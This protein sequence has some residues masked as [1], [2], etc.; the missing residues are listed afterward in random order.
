VNRSRIDRGG[1]KGY[2]D[3]RSGREERV[4]AGY[5]KEQR[6]INPVKK[7]G[8]GE[9]CGLGLLNSPSYEKRV[10]RRGW[11]SGRETTGK[12]NKKP[13]QRTP[14]FLLFLIDPLTNEIKR[15]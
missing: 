13:Q 1:Q 10:E 6:A 2:S 3:L 11:G 12:K 5:E 15:G 9:S 8:G 14:R 4:L 7:G